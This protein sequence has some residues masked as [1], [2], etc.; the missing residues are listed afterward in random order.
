MGTSWDVSY[1]RSTC[2]FYA[3]LTAGNPKYC[4]SVKGITVIPSNE[5]I[6]SKSS[7][8]DSVIGPGQPGYKPFPGDYAFLSK[9]M[10]KMG[11]EPDG[12]INIEYA[13]S[14]SESPIHA[15]YDAIRSTPEFRKKV[16]MLPDYARST[17]AG[18]VQPANGDEILM[19]MVA[20]DDHIPSLCRKISPNAYGRSPAGEDPPTRFL[21]RD[22]CFFENAKY[23]GS[24]A[25]CRAILPHI[26][27]SVLSGGI[28]REECERAVGNQRLRYANLRR[29]SPPLFATGLDF[30]KTLE[31]V[32]YRAP[33]LSEL[34]P[35]QWLRV[36]TEFKIAAPKTREEFLARVQSLPTFT[37]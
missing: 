33:I 34:P 11:Y 3:A 31:K 30:A 14:P 27:P 26:G 19:H 37:R 15:Y 21:L 18:G 6:I 35:G 29:E 10:Q 16:E 2:Y 25:L 20:I 7:C 4:D 1:A 8:L 5:S 28:T 22:E 36:F 13:V 9:V 23:T 24:E 17:P 32:G 12:V